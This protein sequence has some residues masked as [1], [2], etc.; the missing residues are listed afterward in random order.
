MPPGPGA[1]AMESVRLAQVYNLVLRYLLDAAVDYGPLA[2]A[3]RRLQ[4]WLHCVKQEPVRF[5]TAAKA[6]LL[7]QEL[8]PT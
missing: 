1:G 4:C 6:R 3:R 2:G 7:L 5:G 8:G